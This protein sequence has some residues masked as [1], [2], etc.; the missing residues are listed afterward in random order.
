M[1]KSITNIKNFLAKLKIVYDK[2]AKRPLLLHAI[3][4]FL[5]N[6]TIECLGRRSLIAG[7]A[8]LFG[9]PIVFLYNTLVIFMTFCI[10]LFFRRRLFVQGIITVIWLTLGIINFVV[11]GFRSTPISAIDFQII[12]S[13]LNILTVYLGI[14]EIILISISIIFGVY[15]LVQLFR[16]SAK[17]KPKFFQ[18]LL[19]TFLTVA[20]VVGATNGLLMTKQLS[21]KFSSLPVSYK[22]YGFV[23]CF[24][25]SLLN[26]GVNKPKDY[27]VTTVKNVLDAIKADKTNTPQMKPNIVF[28]Q[29]ESFIDPKRLKDVTFSED[30]VPNFTKLKE[31]NTKGY[32][33]V[34]Y[35]GA[36]TANVEFEVMTG[37][38]L[39]HFGPGEY[40][41]K[42]VLQKTTCESICYDLKELGYHASGIHNHTGTFYDRNLVYG[43]L[44]FDTYTSKEFLYNYEK[45]PLGWI[46]D[47]ILTGE[48]MKALTATKEQDLVYTISVQPHGKY[49]QE[50]FT[51]EQQKISLTS[52]HFADK[53]IPIEY[54]VNQIYECDAFLGELIDKL[55]AYP[56]PVILVVYGDH[57]PALDFTDGDLKQGNLY[58]TEYVLWSNYGLEKKDKDL[59]AYELYSDV[60]GRLG[61]NN[62]IITKL[63]QN[64]PKSDA[65]YQKYLE[66]LEYD[67]LYGDYD[68]SGGVNPHKKSPDYRMGTLKIEVTGTLQYGEDLYVYGGNFTPYS[69]VYINGRHVSTEFAGDSSLIVKGNSVATGDEIVVKQV[70]YERIALGESDAYTCP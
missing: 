29:L 45:N 37:M 44:G 70:S 1:K 42:T 39:D 33:T 68:S 5:L 27:S 34:P 20:L 24:S 19:I 22:Q 67:I 61:I 54:Y 46:K 58:Q 7:F 66:I 2:L 25:C 49:P 15:L 64:R 56:E 47:K 32:L 3:L 51:E 11:L 28:L 69:Q 10:V 21:K 41:F 6:L 35:I 57:L 48:I 36:G 60:L 13:A 63:H 26:K 31:N 43:Q 38:N 12:F 59:Y 30:P 17:H 40:P 62:G 53:I 14:F 52:E 9:N 23:Y 4:A 55:S 65:L 16:K 8:H 50:R 18:S